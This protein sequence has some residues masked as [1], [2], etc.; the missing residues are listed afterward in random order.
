M[1]SSSLRVERSQQRRQ[2]VRRATS[3]APSRGT[4]VLLFIYIPVATV[5]MA[6]LSLHDSFVVFGAQIWRWATVR[7]SPAA[8]AVAMR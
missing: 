7:A 1:A 4:I 8:I 5:M 3:G 2:S 6:E